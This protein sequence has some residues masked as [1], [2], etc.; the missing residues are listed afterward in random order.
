MEKLNNH[1]ARKYGSDTIPGVRD[2]TQTLEQ[3]KNHNPMPG[4]TTDELGY[5]ESSEYATNDQYRTH[6]E[7]YNPKT[8]RGTRNKDELGV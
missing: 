4:Q 8:G 6:A 7:Y 2:I 5:V 1:E 3:L